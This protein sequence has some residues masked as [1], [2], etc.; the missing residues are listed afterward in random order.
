MEILTSSERARLLERMT[1]LRFQLPDWL[2][3]EVKIKDIAKLA[4]STTSVAEILHGLFKDHDGLVMP[5]NQTEILMLVCWGKDNNPQNIALTLRSKL[6]EE[7]CEAKTAPVTP[8]GIKRISLLIGM[9]DEADG[10]FYI[11]RIGR[12]SNIFM[13]AD[14]D[15]YM[16]SLVKSGLK[17]LGQVIEVSDGNDVFAFY[18]RYN[19]DML[20]L[21]IHLPSLNGQ[22]ILDQLKK[23]DPKAYVIML[24]ADSSPENVKWTHQHGAAG[25]LAKPFNKPKL[26]EYAKACPTVANFS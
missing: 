14:D 23:L 12:Q 19:P 20:L 21:D 17:E 11:Q 25:F 5:C 15:M 1:Q 26:L 18:Q 10:V 4:L 2:I 6:T 24:S 22:Q 9:P 8:D 13:V 3:V 7:T 16:R